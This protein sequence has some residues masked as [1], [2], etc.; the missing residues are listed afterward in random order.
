M[1]IILTES[2]VEQTAIGWSVKHGTK[3]AS[4]V[5]TA[6]YLAG[7]AGFEFAL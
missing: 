6:I 2:I 5:Y 1:I 4:G 3:I 7:M